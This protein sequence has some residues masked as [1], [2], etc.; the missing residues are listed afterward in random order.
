MHKQ[1]LGRITDFE[2]KTQKL[3]REFEEQVAE[4]EDTKQQFKDCKAILTAMETDYQ[5]M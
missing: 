5:Q 4:T 1:V 3:R 2:D